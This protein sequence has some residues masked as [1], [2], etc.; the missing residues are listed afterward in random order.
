MVTNGA[1]SPEPGFTLTGEFVFIG[2]AGHPD[3]LVRAA[4]H[5]PSRRKSTLSDATRPDCVQV[6][7][8]W[9]AD[10]AR[11]KAPGTIGA[12]TVGYERHFSRRGKYVT[13]NDAPGFVEALLNVQPDAAAYVACK[14]HTKRNRPSSDGRDSQAQTVCESCQSLPLGPQQ[15]PESVTYPSR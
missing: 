13:T 5:T 12:T 8:A 9:G 15:Q 2:V 4:G 1:H 11:D 7:P 3:L 10:S 6:R 14:K